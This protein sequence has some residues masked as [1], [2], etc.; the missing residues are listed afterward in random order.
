MRGLPRGRTV[1]SKRSRSTTR[2]HHASHSQK[3]ASPNAI[4]HNIESGLRLGSV[5][6]ILPIT[7]VVAVITPPKTR[8]SRSLGPSDSLC[9][10]GIAPDVPDY[11]VEVRVR[12][13]GK[14]FGSPPVQMAGFQRVGTFKLGT[15]F[16]FLE[17][18]HGRVGSLEHMRDHTTLDRT[19]AAM[20]GRKVPNHAPST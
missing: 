12:F 19:C 15:V 18:H 13:H 7:S 5:H 20:H 17:Q 10:R 4:V 8:P 9:P 6:A 14:R 11:R 16:F 3:A 2:Q 1:R